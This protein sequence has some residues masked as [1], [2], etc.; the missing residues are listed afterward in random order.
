ML[1]KTLKESGI[2]EFPLNVDYVPEVN[3][4]FSLNKQ[5]LIL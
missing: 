2:Q 3:E 4:D 5:G 1:I